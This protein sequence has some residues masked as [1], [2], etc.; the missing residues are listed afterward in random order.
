MTPSSTRIT[1][2]PFKELS[3][4]T[5]IE[6]HPIEPVLLAEIVVSH[7]DGSFSVA[8][9]PQLPVQVRRQ[10]PNL[11]IPDL[12]NS[13]CAA[14]LQGGSPQCPVIDKVNVFPLRIPKRCFC[15]SMRWACWLK[16][17][18]ILQLPA[19]QINGIAIMSMVSRPA[20]MEAQ[21]R[22]AGRPTESRTVVIEPDIACK[23]PLFLPVDIDG[24]DVKEGL[25]RPSFFETV[26][27]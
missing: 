2:S 10:Q 3:V 26:G 13:H 4:P 8:D 16:V 5:G 17:S 9:C 12:S 18:K 6:L 22:T 27:P 20:S 19:F 24:Q 25:L 14:L 11:T 21:V 23:S 15:L 7:H 1:L